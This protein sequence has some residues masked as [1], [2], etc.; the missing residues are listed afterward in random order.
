MPSTRRPERPLARLVA[1]VA[2]LCAA[3]WDPYTHPRYRGAGATT[4]TRGGTLTFAYD[5]DIN[6]IDPALAADTVAGIPT[7]MI[8]EG[9]VTYAHDS[10]EVVPALAERWDISPDGT[11]YTFHIRPTARFSTGRAVT[12][13]DFVWSWER[14]LDPRRLAS[15]GAENYR[16]IAGFDDYREGR[17]PHL[18]GLSAPDPATLVVTL[19]APDRTFLHLVA[20]RFASA[21]PREVVERVGDE[22]FGQSPVGAGAFVLERWEPAVRVVMRRNPAYWN[23]G[24]VYVERVVMELNIARHLQFMRFLAGELDYANNYSL[25][26]ADY[27][28]VQRNAAWRPYISRAPVSL[29]GAFMMNTEIA[30]FDDVHVRRAVAFAIDRE[31]ICRARNYR[32]APAGALY[33]PGVAGYR[34]HNP[35]AQ[36]FDL[37]AA[38]REMALAGHPNGIDREVELWIG[39]G[40]TGSVYGELVQA[41]LA[42]IGLRVR[43]RQ[44]S[45]SI[46]Y[47]SLGRRHTVPLAFTGWQMDFPDPSN[48]IEPNFHSRAI[49]DEHSSN[50]A[51]YANPALD[52]LLDEAKTEGDPRRRL[53]LYQRAEDVLLRDA[54]WAFVYTPVDLNVLQPWVRHWAHHPVWNDHIEDVWLDLPRRR[55]AASE[56]ARARSFGPFA[57]LARPWGGP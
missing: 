47:S 43:I 45:G 8:H 27:L 56:A 18:S 24:A 34:A 22:R 4:P 5:T 51:F 54:P 49:Q 37:A 12:S 15:P 40:E 52:R 50:H 33:P 28:W 48:F 20:M 38:R 29:I 6:T 31:S 9:L 14:L 19:S 11:R 7:R 1:L 30:P 16:L 35:L 53:A 39:E 3:C 46:Y 55:W 10:T 23:A 26:T 42:R 2:A 17:A 57:A 21:I 41:D 25:S 36:R 44:A 13:H 32:I